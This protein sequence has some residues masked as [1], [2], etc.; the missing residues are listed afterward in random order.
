MYFFLFFFTTLRYDLKSE[1]SSPGCELPDFEAF[2]VFQKGPCYSFPVLHCNKQNVV[3]QGY[4][5]L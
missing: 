4:Y 1:V 3:E 5:K 2:A